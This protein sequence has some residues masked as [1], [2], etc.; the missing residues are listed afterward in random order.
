[1]GPPRDLTGPIND[2]EEVDERLRRT[3]VIGRQTDQGSAKSASNRMGQP[4][5]WFENK[6]R[7]SDTNRTSSLPVAENV[8]N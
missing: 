5:V 6:S 4:V 2:A 3:A 1:M 8:P 7:S